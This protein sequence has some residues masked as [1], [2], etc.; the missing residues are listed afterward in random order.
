MNRDSIINEM[1]QQLPQPLWE[2]WYI[3]EMIGTGSFSAVF[4][5]EAVRMKRVDSAALKIE[6][7]IPDERFAD[8]EKRSLTFLERKRADI[9]EESTIMYKLRGCPNVVAYEDE[10]VKEFYRGGKLAGYIFL[11]RMELLQNVYELMKHRSFDMSE[12]NVIRLALDIGS[13]LKA[14]HDIGVIHRDIKPSNFFV[15]KNGTY[16]L[17]DFNISKQTDHTRS[18]AGTEGYIAPEV[19]RAKSGI[20]GYTAQADIYSFGICLYQMMNNN[21]FPFEE[22]EPTNIAIDRRLSGEPLM[23][24]ENAGAAFSRIILKACEFEPADRYADMDEM[25]SDLRKLEAGK[26][27]EISCVPAYSEPAD[28]DITEYAESP[29]EDDMRHADA[30]V[31]AEPEEKAEVQEVPEKP[32]RKSSPLPKVIAAAALLVLAGGIIFKFAGS[33]DKTSENSSQAVSQAVT[34]AETT[35]STTQTT[36]KAEMSAS[37]TTS[38]AT[39]TTTTTTTQ[40]NDGI[41]FSNN[42]YSI[43]VG[44]TADTLILQYPVNM[45][46]SDEVWES[47]N[48]SV[49]TVNN[50]GQITGVGA[51]ECTVTLYSAKNPEDRA[52]VSVIVSEKTTVATFEGLEGEGCIFQGEY[53]LD[54]DSVNE[55]VEIYDGRIQSVGNEE[56]VAYLCVIHEKSG[57]KWYVSRQ[58]NVSTYYSIGVVSLAGVAIAYDADIN[59]YVVYSCQ[60]YEGQGEHSNIKYLALSDC[61][62]NKSYYVD[63]K[64]NRRRY[65]F[66]DWVDGYTE[67]RE[68]DKS[69]FQEKFS[70]LELVYCTEGEEGWQKVLDWVNNK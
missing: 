27:E 11:I 12:K 64:P 20:S 40:I 38:S 55:L 8:D 47:D 5:A 63:I 61:Y 53:E 68:M 24:P 17:G 30:T 33:H 35:S 65:G 60:I 34:A 6:P 7:I 26:T 59:S 51:G 36:T 54:G 32:E 22:N 41:V 57:D 10:A 25:L 9:E 31:Y 58:G 62:S 42:K 19:Y 21:L 70:S 52:T 15:S 39:T 16:K 48:E 4:R 2:S 50:Y 43:Q 28:M 46:E 45:T 37:T 23:P 14:A 18:F 3:K 44:E 1:L 67:D 69:E 56:N 66:Y 49:A 29:P 13:G